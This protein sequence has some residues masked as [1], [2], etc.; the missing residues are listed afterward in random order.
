MARLRSVAGAGQLPFPHRQPGQH[1]IAPGQV[2]RRLR[3][4]RLPLLPQLHEVQG[5][6]LVAEAPLGSADGFLRLG[7]RR[8]VGQQA[9]HV[10]F[11]RGLQRGVDPVGQ[12]VLL[13]GVQGVGDLG[14]L[15]R[16]RPLG[17]AE[18]AQRPAAEDGAA[19]LLLQVGERRAL[20]GPI[21]GDEL[22]VG[23]ERLPRR[24]ALNRRDGL[25]GGA[26]T[27]LGQHRL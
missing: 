15:T 4:G 19:V 17:E 26:P 10:E 12:V 18:V 1:V 24:A 23:V 22:L 7:Y 8:A 3:V 11:A 13:D 16:H 21:V 6:H 25:A 27:P 14:R 9:P 5:L 2:L 20:P